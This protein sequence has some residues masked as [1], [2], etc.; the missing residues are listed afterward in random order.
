MTALTAEFFDHYPIGT[1]I[2]LADIELKLTAARSWEARY[3]EIMLL[4]KQLPTLEPAL[5]HDEYLVKGCE[6][7]VWL[8]MVKDNND[9][10]HFAA[11]SDAKIVKGLVL[12]VLSLF[13]NKSAQQIAATD[14]NAF[15]SSIDLLKHLSP[16]RS[17]GIKAIIQ[18]ILDSAS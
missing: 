12:I 4:G 15:F 10:Y 14:Y 6:S 13:N 8:H 1:Q 7:K 17:N 5:K 2:T 11:D 18:Q 3:R 9:C 16:S